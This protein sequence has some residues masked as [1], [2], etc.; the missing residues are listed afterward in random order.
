MI[1]VAHR[2][3]GLRHV[4]GFIV[5]TEVLNEPCTFCEEI[6]MS[7][8][9]KA[10]EKNTMLLANIRQYLPFL[11]LPASKTFGAVCLPLARLVSCKPS[12]NRA[13]MRVKIHDGSI[14][15]PVIFSVHAFELGFILPKRQVASNDSQA[16]ALSTSLRYQSNSLS[17]PL[18]LF[19]SSSSIKCQ[20]S[21]L[22]RFVEHLAPV[23]K[24]KLIRRYTF[25][26]LRDQGRFAT[27]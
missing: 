17:T 23:I 27:A 8:G 7:I 20:L 19:V 12:R 24:L 22:H 26:E 10:S 6:S 2:S 3:N 9:I 18:T 4:V 21:A 11:V 25:F 16:A 5:Y 1:K 14:G 13:R 15:G